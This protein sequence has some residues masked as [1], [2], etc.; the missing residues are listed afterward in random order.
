MYFD[1]ICSCSLFKGGTWI[2][3]KDL[4]IARGFLLFITD[5]KNDLCIVRNHWR[6]QTSPNFLKN[7]PMSV[8]PAGSGTRSQVCGEHAWQWGA[9]PWAAAAV[10]GVPVRGVPKREPADR[11]AGGEHAHSHPAVHEPWWLRGGCCPGT[12]PGGAGVGPAE[13]RALLGSKEKPGDKVCPTTNAT[14]W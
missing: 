4:T 5:K 10:V 2:I 8:S 11:P 14:M 9:G 12:E 6:L 3:R 7:L 1:S 13:I